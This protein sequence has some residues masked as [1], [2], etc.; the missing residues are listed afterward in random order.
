MIRG[1]GWSLRARITALLVATLVPLAG[2]GTYWVVWEARQETTNVERLTRESAARIAA[3]TADIIGDVQGMLAVLARLPAVQAR[4]RGEA[5]RLFRELL[6]TSS[7]LENFAAFTTDGTL[8]AAATRGVPGVQIH[9]PDR[10][11]FQAAV[12]S[13]QPVTSDFLVSRI[14]GNPVAVLAYP[15]LDGRGQVL[16]VVGVALRLS[17]L[18][19]EVAPTQPEAQSRW[20]VVDGQDLVLLHGDPGAA[21][22]KPLALLTGML[23][24]EAGVPGTEWRAIVGIPEAVVTAR[25]RSELLDIGFPALLIL[26]V[27]SGVGF[28]IA[29]GTWRPLQ[30]LAEAVRRIGTGEPGV[31]LPVGAT[32]EVGEVATVFQDTLGALTHRKNDLAVLLQA[33]QS[34]AASID[35]EQ[36]LQAIA[37]QASAISDARAVRLFLLEGEP[38]VLRWRMGVGVPPE[39]EQHIVIPVGESFSGEVA[40]TGKPLAVPDCRGDRRL[41]YSHYVMKYGLISYL[42]LPIKSE[43]RV[44]GVL[45]FNTEA[46]RSYSEAEISFLSAF[47]DQAAIAI[48][49]AR[50]FAATERAAR[51]ARSLYEVAHSLATSLDVVDVLQLIAVKTTELL[52]TPHAQVVLWDE[53]TQTLRLGAAYGT[54]AERVK[55][56][57]FRLGEGVNGI[58]AQTRAPLIVNDYQASPHGVPGFTELVAVIGVP[59]LYRD[60][61]LGV[62]TSHATQ[63]GSAFTQE[64]L[65][66]LTSFADQAAVSIENARLYQEIR[67]DAATL[68]AR[69]KGRTAELEEALR[70]KAQFLA[71]MSHELRTPL[72]FILGFAQ[73]LQQGTGGALTP[74]QAQYVDHIQK[75][76]KWLLELVS[77][78]LDLS[79][80]ETGKRG[81]DLEPVLLQ[82][83]VEEVLNLLRVQ[84]VQKRLTVSTALDPGLPFVVADRGKLT[85]ILANLIGNAVKFTP[86]DGRITVTARRVTE[87]R[88]PELEPVPGPLSPVGWL[89]ISVTDTGI[90]IKPEDLERIFRGFE[91]VDS[92]D[93]RKYGGAGLGLALVR[94]LVELHGG[95]VWAESEGPGRGARFVVRLPLLEAPRPKRILVVEDEAVVL[96]VLCDVLVRAGFAVEQAHDGSEALERLVAAQPDLLVLDIGLPDMDGWEVLKRLRGEERTRNL[97]VLVLT[98]LTHVRADQ[99]LALGADEF[100]GKPVS[101]QVLVETAARLLAQRTATSA[102]VQE[103]STIPPDE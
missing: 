78:I 33:T 20:A 89:E 15:I 29:Y 36:S 32:G 54:E 86:D 94:T 87:D 100:L 50:L 48:E 65:A 84:A 26:L 41:R 2:L 49:N 38:P 103:R 93:T 22:G 57:E 76:G 85:Q 101:A 51:E 99:A 91:Q 83:I 55:A 25:V 40:A 28:W 42:G 71:T 47:A 88:R 10:A 5:E 44:V 58:V 8:F 34:L 52:G 23:R 6:A 7:R 12:Q 13:R 39:D 45:V 3:Q 72:N 43:G 102:A 18:S 31:A 80:V 37:Q 77:N 70:V 92:S 64:H 63:P 98:G 67:Q 30:E 62:L 4:D 11:W 79:L 53:G 69:V 59:L 97:P 17:A 16:G 75:G 66:L 46:P 19:Q 27:A 14:T 95:R 90:G 74:K 61:F 21:I 24:G 60:R 96:E 1:R 73:L 35:L 68:A 9:V 56:Q 81:L 82:P